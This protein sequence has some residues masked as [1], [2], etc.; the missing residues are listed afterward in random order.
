MSNKLK[1]GGKREGAGRPEKENKKISYA[2]K[3]RPDQIEWL[4]TQANAAKILEEMI[5][6]RI[7][8]SVHSCRPP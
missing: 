4:R 1:H 3:L 7:E 8:D 6:K 2:T 5:D